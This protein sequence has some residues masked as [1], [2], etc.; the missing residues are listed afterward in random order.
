M[1]VRKR[2]LAILL[3]AVAL[4]A[5]ACTGGGSADDGGIRYT[6][7]APGIGDRFYPSLGNGGYDVQ[8]YRIDL[9]YE[10][11]GRVGGGV[12]I[13]AVAT[14]NLSG[15]NL[16]FAGW[17]ID[18]LRVDQDEVPFTRDGEELV[19]TGV[20]IPDGDPFTV[21]VRY[22]GMPETYP[23]AALPFPIGWLSGSQ[24]EQFVAAEPDAAHSWFPCNDHP[25]DK[26]TFTI[27]VGAPAGYGTAANGERV[28]SDGS[29]AGSASQDAGVASEWEMR[30]PM[31]TYLA[32]VVLGDGWEVVP[33]PVSTEASGVTV[34]NFLPPDLVDDV[35]PE[36]EQTGEMIT[37]L[38]AAFG[39]YPF[40]QY[41]I[42]V[43]DG[44][45]SALENQTLS[46]FDREMVRVPFF[47]EV[48]VHELA[49]QWFGDSVSL[50]DWSDIWLNEGFA[51]YAEMLWTE[52]LDGN[53]AYRED[54][55]NRMQ[56]ARVAGYG[57]PGT[58]EPD[59]LFSGSVY[60]RG[61]LVLAALRDEIGDDAFFTTL[62][63]Y[64][65]RFA[66]GNV[67]TADFIAVAGEISGE[68]LGS[69]FD[70]WVYGEELP[71]P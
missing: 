65:D 37:T 4:F 34:R 41:G 19:V 27:A 56:A 29:D 45:G 52:H 68:D 22:S 60:L 46:I 26:A 43:V 25:L 1:P 13:D 48:L 47:D 10:E 6:P 12:V 39:P 66:D 55:A 57:P 69:F 16:D 54:V 7:G 17:D 32:T 5:G 9:R 8:H 31:T 2:S 62:R 24:G 18:G 40:E 35:P 21:V 28:P 36:L 53:A 71:A 23:S 58:P 33:D 20:E 63:T 15:F 14:Q 42:A 59:D 61:G 44:L 49:H 70:A 30:T 64:A 11:D 38:E 50:A 3:L 51:T 67:T